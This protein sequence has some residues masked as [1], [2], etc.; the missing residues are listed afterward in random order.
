MELVSIERRFI[1]GSG[2]LLTIN[3]EVSTVFDLVNANPNNGSQLSR[4]RI[5]L[6]NSG[7]TTV[8]QDLN[9]TP[10][11]IT[12]LGTDPNN[13]AKTIYSIS[14]TT[15]YISQ[16]LMNQ[17]AT[18]DNSYF[19]YSDC[20]DTYAISTSYISVYSTNISDITDPCQRLDNA[21]IVPST[22]VNPPYEGYAA[23]SDVVGNCNDWGYIHNTGSRIQ[24]RYQGTSTWNSL[25]MREPG[26]GTLR[27]TGI[28]FYWEV[29]YIEAGDLSNG[30]GTYEFRYQNTYPNPDACSSAPWSPIETHTF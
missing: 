27:T 24:Y 3:W 14:F 17:A 7:G 29:L 8:F 21:Y 18:L 30:S 6:K 9:I 22:T 12:S 15:P 25:P 20:D 13:S 23:G 28:V 4:G 5:R 1:C 16:S 11:S 2:Y 10:V 19:I 26:S